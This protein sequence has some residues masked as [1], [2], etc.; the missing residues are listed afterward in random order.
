MPDN[1]MVIVV[2]T[3][4]IMPDK[5]DEVRA[6]LLRQVSRVHVEELGAQ[7]FAAHET[8]DGFVLIEKW[9]SAKS[10]QE[11]TSGAALAEYRRVLD[12]ALLEPP[13]IRVMNALP[14]GDPQKGSL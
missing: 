13:D 8:E 3:M 6:A 1:D 9:D 11:H 2:A 7:L 14:A 10:L 12:P 5:R 4:K